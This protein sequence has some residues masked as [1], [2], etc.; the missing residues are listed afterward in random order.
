MEKT[1]VMS[2]AESLVPT[3]PKEREIYD[4]SSQ[5]RRIIK[6]V[7]FWP[8]SVMHWLLVTVMKPVLMRGMYHWSCASIPGRGGHRGQKHLRRPPRDDPGGKEDAPRTGVKTP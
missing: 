3:P 5:K 7:P 2:G 1:Y 6:V 8:D 4:D